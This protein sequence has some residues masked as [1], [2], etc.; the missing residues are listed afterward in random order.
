M[1]KDYSWSYIKNN[2]AAGI[3]VMVASFISALLLSLLCSLFYNL[4]KYDVDGIK[5]TEGDWQGRI[6]GEIDEKCLAVIQNYANVDQAVINEELSDE[7]KITVDIYF[8]NRRRILEDMPRIARLAGLS[9][10]SVSYHY[11]LLNYYLIRDP[12]DPA[13]RL[14]FPFFLTVTAM[15]C[16]SLIMIIHHS[17][18][19]SMNARIHQFGILSSIGASPGQILSCLMQEAVILCTGPV[20]AG[21]IFGIV[22]SVGIINGI[23][24][25]LADAGGRIEA[26]WGYHPLILVFTFLITAITVCVSAWLPARKLSKLT[27]LEAIRNAGELQLKRKRNS[28]FL[29]ILFGVEGE[30]AGNALKAQ[31]KA[32]RTASWSLVFSF[33]AFTLMQCFFTLSAISQ[34]ETYFERYQNAWDIMATVKNTQIETFEET[35]KLQEL[36]GVRSAVVYQKAAAKRALS[37]EELSEELRAMGG[38]QN[39]PETYVSVAEGMWLVNAPIVVLDDAGFLEY[40]EQIGALPRLDGAVIVNRIR[41]F[42]NSNFRDVRYFPYLNESG[43]TTVLRR[44]GQENTTA[45]IPVISHTQQLPVLKEAFGELDYYVLVHILPVS[46]WK[47]VAGQV[48]GTEEDTYVRI[49]AS[50]GV[51]LTELNA[52]EENV[53]GILAGKYD[54]VTENRMQEKLN[55]DNM[56]DLMMAIFG[57]FCVL[58]AAI[59]IANV[60][61]NTFGFMRQRRR[62]LARYVSVGITPGGIKKMFCVEALV[63]AGRPLLITLPLTAAAVWLMIRASHLNPVVFIKEAPVVPVTAFILALFGFVGLAYYLGGR[64]ML[65]SDL[66]DAL[67]DDTV[68]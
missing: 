29:G 56:V 8:K 32:L 68:M 22:I 10:E 16:I 5:I 51:S 12:E 61:S 45:E 53:A 27:P 14:L 23:N 2:R 37:E 44:S 7:N 25:V 54:A 59:G 19:V 21:V 6:A 31:K 36:S 42:T 67:R 47:E 66:T 64:K 34:R 50:E 55:N 11:S 58:L 48:G 30:L 18:A 28:R 40:C 41:D 33:L 20:V 13:P 1:W 26:P 60:F 3:S 17:F 49:L 4:W 65:R 35:N 24:N 63:I 9:E 62:E 57:G 38:L 52:L 46:V 43:E 39:A 15:A